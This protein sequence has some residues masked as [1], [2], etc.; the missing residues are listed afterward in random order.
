[1]NRKKAIEYL[2]RKDRET[3]ESEIN[4]VMT[5]GKVY[6]DPFAEVDW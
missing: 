3:T 2:K 6:G 5:E 4:K 1:M